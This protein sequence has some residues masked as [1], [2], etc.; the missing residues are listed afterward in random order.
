[1]TNYP[2]IIV[3][4]KYAELNDYLCDLTKE[5]DFVKPDKKSNQTA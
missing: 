3:E 2:R 5:I 1:M 4:E